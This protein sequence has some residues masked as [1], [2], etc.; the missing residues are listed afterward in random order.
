MRMLLPQSLPA[1]PGN[2]LPPCS[3]PFSFSLFASLPLSIAQS[4]LPQPLQHP[5][6]SPYLS[7]APSPAPP[8]ISHPPLPPPLTVPL[9]RPFPR[10]S[11][12]LSPALPSPL[13]AFPRLSPVRSRAT[14]TT[15][16]TTTGRGET[17]W[18]I[19]QRYGVRVKDILRANGLTDVHHV[20]LE[21][22]LLIPRSAAATAAAAAAPAAAPSAAPAAA[23]D[24][25]AL[26]AG[27]PALHASASAQSNSG[28]SSRSNTTPVPVTA[29]AAPTTT[30]DGRSSS[31]VSISS[32]S[33]S[34]IAP[35]R[36]GSS[37]SS[38]SDGMAKASASGKPRLFFQQNTNLEQSEELAL[39]QARA[40]HQDAWSCIKGTV[41]SLYSSLHSSLPQ[42][43]HSSTAPAPTHPVTPPCSLSSSSAASPPTL[44]QGPLL[45][46]LVAS[47]SLALLLSLLSFLRP[48]FLR[49][50]ALQA[51]REAATATANPLTPF[52]G[53]GMGVA[54]RG[55]VQGGGGVLTDKTGA[56][57]G[58]VLP[59]ILLLSS[60]HSLT[61]H[62]HPPSPP[63]PLPFRLPFRLPLLLPFS[64]F[65]RHSSPNPKSPQ[66]SYRPFRA[67]TAP[68][69][70]RPPPSLPFPP[71]P[72][73]SQGRPDLTPE[74]VARDYEEI[75]RCYHEGMAS[76]YES[77][78]RDSGPMSAGR[79]QQAF[80]LVFQPPELLKTYISSRPCSYR[81]YPSSF[82]PSSPPPLLTS[83]GRPDLT[84]EDVARDYEEIVRCYHEGM[85]SSYESF[86]RDSGAMSAGRFRG[87]MPPKFRPKPKQR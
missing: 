10:P 60:S 66:I 54:Q 27:T 11:P 9:T 55:G 43:W 65:P 35:R 62:P 18:G 22:T 15:T 72:L 48:I 81:S 71:P 21:T 84:P 69:P 75:V 82:H 13:S 26:S 68:T 61:P 29:A 38:R 7:P 76:S 12:Y 51:E 64:P 56:G 53:L 20:E 46:S 41:S 74:D 58:I 63:H 23:S 47:L 86:L 45:V 44:F 1:F 3:L 16:T 57:A 28:S 73:P 25:A 17:L 52:G 42:Q 8:R 49:F 33:A 80:P 2:K 19:S 32:D 40:R 67:L 79:F 50:R 6:P 37:S 34:A 70:F 4:P 5:R 85:A 39:L 83:Q 77:F 31:S 36:T 78:L 87:G 24:A 30:V 59:L 14:T